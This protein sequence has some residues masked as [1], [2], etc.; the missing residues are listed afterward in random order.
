MFSA[1]ET[2]RLFEAMGRGGGVTFAPV[3]TGGGS[4]AVV[5]E[6]LAL[7][8]REFRQW[9]RRDGVVLRNSDTAAGRLARA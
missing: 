8:F 6:E 3:V 7:A 1:P 5:R 4:R 2:R 9:W